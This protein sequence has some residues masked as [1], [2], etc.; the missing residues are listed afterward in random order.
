MGGC[1]EQAIDRCIE[2]DVL[3]RFL[4]EHR[5]E[6]VRVV[7]LDYTFDRQIELERIDSRE[8]GYTEGREEG[9]T[10][11]R[12]EGHG[13]G[14]AEGRVRDSISLIGKKVKKQKTLEQI[15]ADLEEE[16]EDIRLLYDI[17]WSYA[18]TCNEDQIYQAY[19]KRTQ[20]KIRLYLAGTKILTIPTVFKTGTAKSR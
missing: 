16:P 1:I 2:E 11:G 18:P 17:V 3:R 10:E 12:Q 6:V 20:E 4:I 5:L 14:L 8:E 13:E 15:A 19:L 7:Q 9:Y